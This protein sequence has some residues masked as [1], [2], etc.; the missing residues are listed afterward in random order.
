MKRLIAVA[1][2]WMLIA[3]TA[4]AANTFGVEFHYASVINTNIPSEYGVQYG[5]P[6]QNTVG[7]K[8]ESII[9]GSHNLPFLDE[10]YGQLLLEVAPMMDSGSE[11]PFVHY[12]TQ[13]A[14]RMGIGYRYAYHGGTIVVG[15]YHWSAHNADW[16]TGDYRGG[17]YPSLNFNAV[18]VTWTIGDRRDFQLWN[19]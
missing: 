9:F 15:L 13:V 17:T 11:N 18:Q 5:S 16:S 2:L 6:N 12:P 7:Y 3:G 19:D 14:L 10:S 8:L 1:S 4:N